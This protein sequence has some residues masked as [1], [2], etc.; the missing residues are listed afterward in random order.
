MS[1]A[2]P[3]ILIPL[4]AGGA[5]YEATAKAEKAYAEADHSADVEYTE[6][7]KLTGTAYQAELAMVMGRTA[8]QIRPTQQ[9]M[10]YHFNSHGTLRN[11]IGY[12][13][14]ADPD[15]LFSAKELVENQKITPEQLVHLTML[16]RRQLVFQSMAN[17]VTED[18]A[19]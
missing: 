13:I 11:E 12:A 1:G 2:V 14:T 15:T 3:P 16:R 6:L 17:A 18:I 10:L 19:V 7:T 4:A 9:N 8:Q 5:I